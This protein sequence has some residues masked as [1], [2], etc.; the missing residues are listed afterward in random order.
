M[1]SLHVPLEG[2][3]VPLVVRVP[4]FENHCFNVHSEIRSVQT[5][6]RFKCAVWTGPDRP[7]KFN[8]G[9]VRS[10]P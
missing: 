10:G 6:P 3:R 9:P 2:A 5:G 8:D 1:R 4:Q 7:D